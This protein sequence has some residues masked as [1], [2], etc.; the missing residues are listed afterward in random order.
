MMITG[1]SI[2]AEREDTT[3]SQEEMASNIGVIK[4]SDMR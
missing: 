1:K 3:F 2:V 4:S